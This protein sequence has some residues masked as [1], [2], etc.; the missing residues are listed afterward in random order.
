MVGSDR[1]SETTP[2][3][4][5]RHIVIDGRELVHRPTGVGRYLLGILER[6][7]SNQSSPHKFTVIVPGAVPA[8]V[9]ALAPRIGTHQVPAGKIGTRFE[10]FALPEIAKRLEADVFFAPAYTGPL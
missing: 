1:G 6:W 4:A 9:A 8:E 2:V 5:S 7:A 10:Q 3:S